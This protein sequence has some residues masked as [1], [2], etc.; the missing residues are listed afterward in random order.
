MTQESGEL[1]TARVGAYTVI[2]DGATIGDDAAIGS[3]AVIRAG[4][5]VG[6][7]VL[8]EDGALLGGHVVLED[9]TSIGARACLPAL[10]PGDDTKRT[11]VRAG[12]R[13]GAAATVVAGVEVGE[14]A[15]VAPGSV[16]T[17]TVPR[18]AIVSGNP[19]RITGYVGLDGPTAMEPMRHSSNAAG[20]SGPAVLETAVRGVQ[21]HR[22]PEVRDLRGSLVAGELEAQFP[23]IPRRYFLVFDVPG[24]DVRGEHAHY[25]CHQFLVAVHGEV[26]VIADDGTSRQEFVLD[27]QRIGLYLPPMVWGV[28]YRYSSECVLLVLASHPYDPADYIR[29]Y[30]EYLEVARAPERSVMP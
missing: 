5:R 20:E 23:F 7:S 14:G 19:A 9:A 27:E 12:A 15:V 18:H 22:M 4:A 3:H 6:N 13:I 16:V 17:R 29:D 30:A 1:S 2:E 24:A 26:H 8:I 25:R 28:Q 21:L 11:V 10:H